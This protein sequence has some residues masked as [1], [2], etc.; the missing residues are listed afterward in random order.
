MKNVTISIDEDLHRNARIYA[1]AHG[2][3]LSALVKEY[4][5]SLTGETAV[6]APNA[7]RVKEMPVSFAF[8]APS[9]T[10]LVSGKLRQP[11]RFRGMNITD[12]LDTWPDDIMNSFEA[13]ADYDDPDVYE[14]QRKSPPKGKA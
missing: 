11:G 12:T 8:E 5:A 13:W 10:P 7:K 9:P 1:A 3:S 4:L 14:V 6:G 2:T